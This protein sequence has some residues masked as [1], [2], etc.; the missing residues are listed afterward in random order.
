MNDFLQMIL[1]FAAY[2]GTWCW[3]AKRCIDKDEERARHF[4]DQ[5]R[6]RGLKNK[7]TARRY[8]ERDY[9]E[10]LSLDDF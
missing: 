3:W 2:I 1:I 7:Q 9:G 4:K 6:A 5:L 8:K 10:P